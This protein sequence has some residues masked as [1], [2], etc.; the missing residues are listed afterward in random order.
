MN[1]DFYDRVEYARKT[2]VYRLA[3]RGPR[4]MYQVRREISDNNKL[5][6]MEGLSANLLVNLK[7]LET[8]EGPMQGTGLT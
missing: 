3:D 4:S 2:L 5:P 1:Q 6:P 7:W 8:G